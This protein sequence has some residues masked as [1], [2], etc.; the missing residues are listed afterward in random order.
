MLSIS[1]M[2]KYRLTR[3]TQFVHRMLA[4]FTNTFP[5]PF[6]SILSTLEYTYLNGLASTKFY[7]LGVMTLAIIATNSVSHCCLILSTT[8][9]TLWSLARIYTYTQNYN[10]VFGNNKHAKQIFINGHWANGN[11][12]AFID[13]LSD[14]QTQNFALV[15]QRDMGK[16]YRNQWTFLSLWTRPTSSFTTPHFHSFSY[17]NFHFHPQDGTSPH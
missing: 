13:F 11:L 5:I 10:N 16:K 4:M 3:L 12:H 17:K 8:T 1:N 9:F 6:H 2:A 15:C 14:L 7:P